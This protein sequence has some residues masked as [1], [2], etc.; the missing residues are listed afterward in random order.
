MRDA[1]GDEDVGVGRHDELL[2]QVH[3]RIH[4][5]RELSRDDSRLWRVAVPM[6]V[7]VEVKVEVAT[8]E[9]YTGGVSLELRTQLIGLVPCR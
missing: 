9:V 5:L 4:Q 1:E 3:H 7:E 2:V 8:R 6:E